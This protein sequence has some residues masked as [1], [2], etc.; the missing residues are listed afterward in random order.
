MRVEAH[1]PVVE[2][3]TPSIANVIDWKVQMKSAH[4]PQNRPWE[5]L[6]TVPTFASGASAFVYTIAGSRG[7]QNE[8]HIEGIASSGGGTPLGSTS[9]TTG[10]SR[11]LKVLAVNNSAEYSQSGIYQQISHGGTNEFHGTIQYS[12]E[13]SVLNARGRTSRRRGPR[14]ATTDTVFPPAVRSSCRTSTMDATGPSSWFRT[15]P[16]A[17]P[18]TP[19][20]T[21]MFRL[22]RC[23]PATSAVWARFETR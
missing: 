9:M 14:D 1:S 6:I 4:S 19:R 17:P 11:E 13:N 12:H 5:A 8:F 18:G 7:A 16:G 3:E 23:G 10:A 15:K 22:R 21:R 2:S 20:P